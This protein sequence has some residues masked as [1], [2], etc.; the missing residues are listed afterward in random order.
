MATKRDYY[1]VLGVTQTATEVEIKRAFRARAREYHPDVNK[2]AGAE[3]QFKEIIEAY[4][5]LSDGAKRSAYDRFGHAGVNGAGQQAYAGFDAFADIFDQF[6]GAGGQ[7]G[8][9]G[10]QRG[11]DL[12]YDLDIEFE[13]A[14]F[15]VE[16]VLEI[17]ALRAC[18]R[19][20]GR[21]LEPNSKENTCPTC[22]GSGE[23]RRVQQSVFGQFVNVVMCDRCHGE[24]KIPGEP[25]VKCQGE[26]RERVT[27]NVTVKIPAG[28]DNGQQIRL[29]G[30]G[31][32]GPKGGPAGDLYVVLSVSSHTQFQ[33]NGTQIQFELPITVAQAALG[34]QVDVPTLEGSETVRVPAGTQSGHTIRLRGRGVPYLRGSGRGD[35]F[36]QVRVV[37]PTKLTSEQRVLFENL[38]ESLEVESEDRGFFG[39]VKEAF[40][41]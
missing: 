11:A 9:R 2:K 35:L 41:G 14:I 33:R 6:F 38:A 5:V 4:E 12:R 26:G 7:R 39:R 8:Q 28:V 31:E 36:V 37:V 27:R 18:S 15:G 16:R 13:E 24:G 22:H 21:G 19:C 30:E 34:D 40:G 25:C 32:S 20:G 29:T 17:P 3:T 23:I 1:E 10:P